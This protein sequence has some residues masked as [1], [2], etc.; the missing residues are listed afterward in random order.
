MPFSKETLDFL[1]EN[2]VRNDKTWFKEHDAEYRKYVLIP[3]QQLVVAL[4]PEMQ[5]IDAALICEPKIGRSVSRIY[6]DTRFSLDKSIFR[7]VMWCVFMRE[8]QL[9]GGLPGFF[10]EL[11]PRLFRYGCG[12]YQASSESMQAY[13]KLVLTGDVRFKEAKDAY[14]KQDR[15]V[16]SGD[17]FKRSRHKDAPDELKPWLDRKN[18]D[19]LRESHDF[20]GELFSSDLPDMLAR[21]FKLLKPVYELM[22][23]AEESIQRKGINE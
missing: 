7:D 19:F 17:M 5:G 12:Y 10:F 13:R 20:Q 15:F 4:A 6:R 22:M 14:E 23:A 18:I 9:Y 2:R 1:L 3:L 16:L 21:D 11:S 8:K